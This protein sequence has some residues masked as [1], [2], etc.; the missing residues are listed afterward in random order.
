MPFLIGVLLAASVALFASFVGLDRDRAFYSTVVMVVASYYVL[1]AAIGGSP[2][3]L[4]IE[5]LVALAFVVSAAA[6][7]R[8]SQWIVVA[9]LA[10]HGLFDLVHC[11][12]IAN[13]GVPASW[14]AFCMAYDLMAAACLAWLLMRRRERLAMP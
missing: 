11:H 4:I 14:P 12:L 5:S 1:F 8:H 10:A 2:H 6:G 13:S 3:S 7:F 9:A